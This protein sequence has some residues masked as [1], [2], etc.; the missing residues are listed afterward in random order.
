MKGVAHIKG[1][2]QKCSHGQVAG[3]PKQRA[4]PLLIGDADLLKQKQRNHQRCRKAVV[5]QAR[6]R[7]QVEKGAVLVTAP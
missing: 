4:I 1:V 2:H 5:E 7:G 6:N 3:K